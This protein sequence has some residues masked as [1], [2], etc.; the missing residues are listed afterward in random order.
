MITKPSMAYYFNTKMYAGVFVDIHAD[1][2]EIV[3][4]VY[5]LTAWLGE[6]GGF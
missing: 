3:R 5:S 2:L 6:V 1:K 4:S